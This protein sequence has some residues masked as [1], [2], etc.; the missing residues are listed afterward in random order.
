MTD[1]CVVCY[2][3]FKKDDMISVGYQD[4]MCVECAKTN[5]KPEARLTRKEV[6]ELE[7]KDLPL[8]KG[9]TKEDFSL[10]F[11]R[12]PEWDNAVRIANALEVI[13][14][15]QGIAGTQ[16]GGDVDALVFSALDVHYMLNEIIEALEEE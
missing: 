7:K 6:R 4:S 11:D 14:S 3:S 9:P 15:Y 8:I 12:D 1:F 2:Y 16:S 13:D 5:L 10:N